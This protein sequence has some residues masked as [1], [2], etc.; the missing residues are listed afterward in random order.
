MYDEKGGIVPLFYTGG[1][2]IL[3][4]VKEAGCRIWG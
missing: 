2:E 4:T 3:N 1:A